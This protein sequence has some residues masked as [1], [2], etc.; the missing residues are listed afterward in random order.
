[1]NPVLHIKQ[2]RLSYRL[3][4]YVLLCSSFFTLLATAVQIYMDYRRD[5]QA[6][7]TNIK[8]IEDSYLPAITASLFS[9]DDEQLATLL[10]GAL[11]LPD[12]EYLKV[13][14]HFGNTE[15]IISQGN[16][17]ADR[18]LI[19]VYHL[20]YHLPSGDKV[21]GGTLIVTASLQGIYQRLRSRILVVLV[22]NG[23]KTFVAAFFILL[24]IQYVI[25]RHLTTM[26]KFTQRL[27]LDKL[28]SRLVLDRTRWK[29]SEPDELDQVVTALN[30]MRER[31]RSDMTKREKAENALRKSE[32]KYRFVTENATDVLWQTDLTG[33]LTFVSPSF[34]NLLGYDV[35][36]AVGMN[37]LELLTPESEKHAANLLQQRLE[38]DNKFNGPQVLPFMLE[39]K[40][41]HKQGDL[42][43]CEVTAR[44]IRDNNNEPIGITGVTRNITEKKK[45]ETQLLQAQK[46]EAIGTLAGGIAHD[47]NNIL[48]AIMGYTELARLDTPQ[49][50]NQRKMLDEVLNSSVRAKDLVGRILT[51]SRKDEH[52]EKL[53]QL[54]PI[55]KEGLKMLR[56]SIPSTI[57][58]QQNIHEQS[59]AVMIDP[60]QIHQVLM[61]LC[62]N[63][64]HAMREKG[65]ILKVGLEDIDLDSSTVSKYPGLV[66][67][68]YVKLTVSDTGHGMSEAI[69][70][71]I[72]DPYFTTKE[73]GKGTGLGLSVLHG[74][75][76]SHG[77]EIRVE[78][79]PDKGTTF[80][81]F[82]PEIDG[83]PSERTTTL[84]ILPKGDKDKCILFVDDEQILVNLGQ[85]MLEELGYNFVVQTNPVKAL[86]I[87]RTEPD[88]FDLVITDQTMPIMTG[89][90][91]AEELL[92]IR[93]DIPIVLCTGYSELITEDKIKT[94]GIEEFVMKPYELGNLAETIRKV[95][96]R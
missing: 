54:A 21:T 1:M 34:K 91:L 15:Y 81:I 89:E 17:D 66:P 18:D 74:I 68:P 80:E 24:I 29:T 77:G 28:D 11:K 52:E 33:K 25:T 2:H 63:A 79:E 20:E 14:E 60:I 96:D 82:L 59:W 8:F 61:N 37:M 31:M 3:L 40:Y 23:I 16:P 75:V 22:S 55:I 76:K 67:G 46:M 58:I 88:K 10:Q 4:F 51:F 85:L 19:R 32:E 49:E 48:A 38:T 53:V 78:S 56:A 95:L 50:S 44:F 13:H 43:H 47:F 94:V 72:F 69:K 27:D 84:K 62:T 36:E 30:D 86:E 73:Q 83:T 6:I 42:R 26:A 65:G 92:N 64:A 87:F 93:P 70:M 39:L 5:V 7:K 41:K 35:E 45:L 90:K 12:I 57:E 9:M 71:K